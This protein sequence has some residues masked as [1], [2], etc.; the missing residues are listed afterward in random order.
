MT[1][2]YLTAEE[3][4]RALPGFLAS[5]EARG[6]EL[7]NNAGALIVDGYLGDVL[8]ALAAVTR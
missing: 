5:L 2:R 1:G 3:V 8:D 4:E 6:V 7:S